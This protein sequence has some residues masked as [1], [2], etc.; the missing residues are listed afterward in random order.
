[1][2]GKNQ[3]NLQGVKKYPDTLIRWLSNIEKQ[4]SRNIYKEAYHIN[5]SQQP[6]KY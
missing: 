5:Q 1:M 4:Y 6:T 2:W 3:Q